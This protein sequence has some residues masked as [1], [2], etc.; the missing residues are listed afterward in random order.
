MRTLNWPTVHAWAL[1]DFAATAYS[2]NLISTYFALWVQQHV[3]HGVT[4]AFAYGL[5]NAV[6]MGIVLLMSP[7]L[8]ARSDRSGRRRPYLV[9]CIAIYVGATLVLGATRDLLPGIALFGFANVAFQ[10]SM[11]FYNAML[12]AIAPAPVLGR[13]SGYGKMIGYVG[14]L[15][16][17]LLGMAFATG[18]LLGHPLPLPAGG[19]QAVFVPTA[20]LVALAALPL[21]VSGRTNAPP[22]L[23]SRASWRRLLAD[24]RG[25]QQLP[26]VGLFLLASFFFFDTVN[27]IRS[28]MSLYL[29]NVVHLSA[30]GGSMQKFLLVV[31]LCSL[32]GA[33]GWGF[34]T[35]RFGA[36]STLVAIL[37][38]LGVGFLGLI[39]V[40][41]AGIVTGV[42]GPILGAAFGGVL[43]ATRPLLSSL[44]PEDRQGEFFGLFVL[45]NEC[46][47]ILGPLTWGGTVQMLAARG[48]IA[49]EAALGVQLVFLVI[50]I[51]LLL[52]VPTPRSPESAVLASA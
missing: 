35:D 7:W 37:C 24:L 43:V 15:A 23:E 18:K 6:S 30:T 28:F 40:H 8:G 27:T 52:R 44:V 12:P 22:A 5:I 16:A 2:M 31:V 11:V 41:S 13:I 36:K 14:S 20:L 49:Y 50:G 47:A 39:F 9:A 1:Y 33:L 3:A 48:A 34:L 32:I 10:L 25:A 45:A 19:A 38:T 17:V 29:V 46:A 42:F 4:G 21:C 26:G 51:L